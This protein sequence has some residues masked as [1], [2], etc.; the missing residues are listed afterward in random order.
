MAQVSI[1]VQGKSLQRLV[2]T[3]IALQAIL[4]VL[5]HQAIFERESGKLFWTFKGKSLIVESSHTEHLVAEDA[6]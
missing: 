3:P 1:H 5:E 2:T 6:I 4:W